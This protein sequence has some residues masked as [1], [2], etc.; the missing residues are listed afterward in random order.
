MK[1]LT[2]IKNISWLV[3]WNRETEN[4]EY[5]CNADLVFSD[6]EIVFAGTGYSQDAE[7]I[8]DGTGILVIPGM[9]SLHTHPWAQL[10]GKGY[11]EDMGM[12]DRL[13]SGSPEYIF[14]LDADVE[15]MLAATEAGICELLKSG[16]TTFADLS[17]PFARGELPDWG[18]QWL[19]T[20]ETSGIRAYACP[21]ARD[22][23]WSTAN[24]HEMDWVWDER[25]GQQEYK[26]GL[27]LV[28]LAE[29]HPNPCLNGMLGVAQVDTATAKVFSDSYKAAE[30]RN[31][32]LQTHA[33]QAAFEVE[34]IYRRHGKTP[35]EWLADIGALGPHMLLGHGVYTELH[36]NAGDNV[37]QDIELISNS[38][39]TV[40][41]CPR[42]FAE[43]GD[44]LHSFHRYREA[45]INIAFGTD[46]MQLNMIEEIRLGL[47]LNR[48]IDSLDAKP[49]TKDIFDAATLGGAD[50]LQRKDLGRLT[51]GAKADI[52]LVDLKHPDMRPARD[53]LRNLIYSASANAVKDVYVNGRLVVSDGNVLTIDQDDALDRLESGQRRA[54]QK[55]PQVHY[56]GLSADE[57]A[58]LSLRVKA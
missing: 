14:P 44:A 18:E 57:M 52:V 45:G 48:V 27:A 55:V 25:L 15:T 58:P 8:K 21:M 6:D 41:H 51:A 37:K 26:R 39:A 40:V 19:E 29:Q 17:T 24:G 47:Y 42:S 11:Y 49:N 9:L 35:I 33:S 43:M 2:W 7:T 30:K 36:P 34:E 20:L 56:A 38:G 5:I 53:P 4:H 46:T 3:A 16:C 54:A 50:A 1:K 32:P 12:M 28:D 10:P 23:R 31:I 22:A 13:V